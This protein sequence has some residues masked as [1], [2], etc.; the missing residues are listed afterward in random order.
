MGLGSAALFYFGDS[1]GLTQGVSGLLM[2]GGVPPPVAVFVGE[3]S[4]AVI[5]AVI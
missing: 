4:A 1:K 5:I 2:L 3:A